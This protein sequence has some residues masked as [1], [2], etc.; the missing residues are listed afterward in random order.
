MYC[1]DV[2]SLRLGCCV[3][4]GFQIHLVG[5][6]SMTATTYIWNISN[7]IRYIEISQDLIFVWKYVGPL[8]GL[9]FDIL[10]KVKDC[11]GEC[12]GIEGL[13]FNKWKKTKHISQT[14][15]IFIH[16]HVPEPRFC[17][18]CLDI[19]LYLV[20]NLSFR[21]ITWFGVSI[22]P[23]GVWPSSAVQPVLRF[24]APE[25]SKVHRSG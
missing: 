2:E 20:G 19:Y 3:R 9:K 22:E 21:G 6:Y 18:D 4:V 1:W 5:K 11:S 7:R 14:I 12:F 15:Q 13:Q 16:K 8:N 25:I 17:N 10:G 24:C 23:L